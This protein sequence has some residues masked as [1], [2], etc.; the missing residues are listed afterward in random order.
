MSDSNPHY[1]GQVKPMN[2]P[3][4]CIRMMCIKC[5]LGCILEGV[6]DGVLEDVS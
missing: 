6:L 2:I 4:V 1:Q 3:Y 5:V